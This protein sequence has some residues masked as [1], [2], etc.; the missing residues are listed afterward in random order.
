MS[1]ESL[2]ERFPGRKVLIVGDAMLD[3]YVTGKVER[4]SPEAPVVVLHV[5]DR[6]FVPGGCTNVS[7]NCSA[8]GMDAHIIAVV[9]NDQNAKVL[10]DLLVAHRVDV[11]DLFIAGDRPTITKMRMIAQGQQ[12]MRVDEEATHFVDESTDRKIRA[13]IEKRIPLVDAVI[14]SDYAKGACTPDSMRVLIDL[15]RKHNKPVIVDS[16]TSIPEMYQSCTVITPNEFEAMRMT[17]MHPKDEEEFLR[18][19]V[20]L[21]KHLHSAVLITRGAKGMTLFEEGRKPHTMPTKAVEVYDVTGAGDTVTAV[22]CA[23]I[24]AQGSLVDGMTLAT[25]AAGIVIRQLGSATVS[26]DELIHAVRNDGLQV[27]DQNKGRA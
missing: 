8:L 15:A 27:K 11:Q 6:S 1:V 12:L 7:L 16:K 22:L 10:R 21:Q 18:M 20:D 2:V 25:Y 5:Q 23:S 17:G 24:A 4:I 3:V 26:R 19:G 14:V 9:G 13:A